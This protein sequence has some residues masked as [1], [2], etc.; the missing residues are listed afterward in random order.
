VNDHGVAPFGIHPSFEKGFKRDNNQWIKRQAKTLP[1]KSAIA[2]GE[3]GSMLEE[4]KKLEEMNVDEKMEL[5]RQHHH[6]QHEDINGE[7]E[8]PVILGKRQH[9]ST[10]QQEIASKL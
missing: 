6:H 1:E 3:L 2:L 8:V 5:W 4:E 10:S 9:H 7:V